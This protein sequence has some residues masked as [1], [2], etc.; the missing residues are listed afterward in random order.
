VVEA[1]DTDVVLEVAPG[2][3]MRFLRR[4][5][6][7]TLPDDDGPAGPG[8]EAAD[9]SFDEPDS[10]QETPAEGTTDSPAAPEHLNG[11]GPA[12]TSADHTAQ[13][14]RTAD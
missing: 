9:S 6:M 12:G 1:D 13:D 8:T 11:S 7:E 14:E 4:A 3:H 2:V 10:P 5:V